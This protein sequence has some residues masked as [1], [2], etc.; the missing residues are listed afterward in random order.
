MGRS[1]SPSGRRGLRRVDSRSLSPIRSVQ[2]RRSPDVSRPRL[3]R[4]LSGSR[5]HSVSA[6]DSHA[7]ATL[8]Q[9]SSSAPVCTLCGEALEPTDKRWGKYCQHEACGRK[10]N[11]VRVAFH[12][13]PEVCVNTIYRITATVRELFVVLILC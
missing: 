6:E 10:M 1:S 2:R 5:L 11:S 3:S 13:N 4:S 12:R 7:Q 9:P 8:S